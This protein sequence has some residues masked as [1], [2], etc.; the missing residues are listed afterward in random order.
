MDKFDYTL[1]DIENT[2]GLVPCF[3]KALSADVIIREWPLFKKYFLGESH[4]PAK[5]WEL[6]GLSIVEN[7]ICPNCA[8]FDLELELQRASDFGQR[9]IYIISCVTARWNAMIK[10]R[11]LGSAHC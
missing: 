6:K 9:G 2:I 3:M 1:K 7:T 5:Y 8:L 11:L 4:T 10:E